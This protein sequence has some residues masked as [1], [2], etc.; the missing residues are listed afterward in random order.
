MWI[1]C[2]IRVFRNNLAL[3]SSSSYYM[4]SVLKRIA[5]HGENRCNIDIDMIIL[6]KSIISF[7]YRGIT[8]ILTQP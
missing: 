3:V 8:K 5:R 7:P 4:I 2:S 1:D 6:L